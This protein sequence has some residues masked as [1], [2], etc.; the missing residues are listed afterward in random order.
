MTDK[1]NPPMVVVE[2]ED[3]TN[4]A[5]WHDYEKVVAFS[6]DEFDTDWNCT[7]V[8]YL[9]REDEEC[10]IVASR[11][12]GNFEQMGLAERIPRGMVKR[13]SYLYEGGER[14]DSTGTEA[15]QPPVL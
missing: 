9:L 14:R 5:E 15:M 4:A 11:A 8:G 7:N 1:P 6:A 12:T 3:A 2:W 10:V 13:I